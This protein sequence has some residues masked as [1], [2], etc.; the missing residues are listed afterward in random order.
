MLTQEQRNEMIDQRI[1]MYDT[2]IFNLQMDR[3]ALES[4]GDSIGVEN[5][6]QRI[7]ALETAREAVKAMK[8]E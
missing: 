6:D 2:Q 7:H 8:E 3:T 1:N 5:V 4:V